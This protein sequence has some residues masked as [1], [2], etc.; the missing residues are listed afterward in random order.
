M[1]I[2]KQQFKKIKALVKNECANYVNE[3][4]IL[5]GWTCP[6]LHIT[7]DLC[8]HFKESVLPLDNELMGQL[9]GDGYNKICQRCGQRF[10][11]DSPNKLL[12]NYCATASIR[13]KKRE[14][15][16]TIRNG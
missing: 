9:L 14:Y 6:Q 7:I 3:E 16:R 1:K 12:C 4:C 8:K 5:I 2:T 11:A 13:E 10:N 15:M